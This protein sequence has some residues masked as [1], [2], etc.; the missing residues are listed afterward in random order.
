MLMTA[1]SMPTNPLYTAAKAGLV[2]FTRA[3]G[4]TFTSNDG[5][6]V[7]CICPAFI[8]TN[9]CP[10][11]ALA[12]FPKEHITPMSTCLKAIDIFLGDDTMTG[13]AVELTLD[14]LHFREKPDYPNESQR[15]LGEESAKFWEDAYKAVPE[16]KNG[17]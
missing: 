6:T 14:E 2:G 4:P 13:Q 11:H 7:N 1:S 5:I 3:C 12:L 15:W 17:V 8:T 16:G 9:L 10:P